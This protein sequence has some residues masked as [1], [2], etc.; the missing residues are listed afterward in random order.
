MIAACTHLSAARSALEEHDQ[1]VDA[2]LE[3]A[4]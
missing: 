4:L 2:P 3:A 1:P